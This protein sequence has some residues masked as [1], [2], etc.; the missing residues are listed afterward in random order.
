MFAPPSEDKPRAFRIPLIPANQR[1]DAAKRRIEVEEPQIA[2]RE[3]EFFVVERIV[4]DVHLAVNPG[5]FSVRA[6]HRHRVVI[7]PRRAA[8]KQRRD[9]D[10]LQF[11]REFAQ[12]LRGR[13]GNR[14]GQGE[15][16]VIFFAAEILGA[17][18]FLEADD[19]RASGR[20]FANLPLGLGQVLVGIERATGLDQSDPEFIGRRH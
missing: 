15:Q 3:V 6:Q 10:D 9:D 20:G 8:L 14:F 1:A 17:E 5:D 13:A 16:I 12:S 4:G 7:Q 2:G 11:A 18:Q 19:L